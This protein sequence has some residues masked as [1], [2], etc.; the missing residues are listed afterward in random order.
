MIKVLHKAFDIFEFLAETPDQPRSLTEIAGRLGQHPATCANI[1]KTMVSRNYIEQVAPK[2]GYLLGPALF[3]LSRQAPYRKDLTAVAEPLMSD[4]AK[5]VNETVLLVTLCLGRRFILSQINGQQQIQI[6][7]QVLIHNSIYE[8]ATGRLLLAYLPEHELH[9]IVADHG[10]PGKLWPQSG[11]LATLKKL[12]EVIQK[13]GW[14]CHAPNS[15]IVGIAFPVCDRGGHVAAALGL[16]LPAF[17]FKGPHRKSVISG[18]RRT[19]AAIGHELN[20]KTS[21]K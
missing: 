8:T 16:F 1:L 18:L 10:L 17:R 21:G 6:G 9:K 20:R 4:L 12:L 14:V 2:K 13:K 19:A 11:T 3:Q 15:E 7:H 5:T